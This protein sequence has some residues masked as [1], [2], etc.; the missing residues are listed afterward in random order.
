M[1]VLACPF[2]DLVDFSTKFTPLYSSPPSTTRPFARL[3][4]SYV[5][6]AITSSL[7]TRIRS[8]LFSEQKWPC[9]ACFTPSA[10]SRTAGGQGASHLLVFPVRST[11]SRAMRKKRNAT[12]PSNARP[13]FA[14]PLLVRH[15]YDLVQLYP[16]LLDTLSIGV[17]QHHMRNR[18]IFLPTRYKNPQLA[19]ED[20]QQTVAL[21]S[22]T[23]P[24]SPN[25]FTPTHH[26]PTLTKYVR[27][28]RHP[29]L[30]LPRPPSEQSV[31]LVG[32]YVQDQGQRHAPHLRLAVVLIPLLYRPTWSAASPSPLSCDRLV[33]RRS[34]WLSLSGPPTVGLVVP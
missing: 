28:V 2:R 7:S 15:A 20:E 5:V 34:V 14:N 19:M 17:A 30:D 21:S 6:R 16:G 29:L 3:N 12:P 10:L 24:H 32:H 8:Q 27:C 25:H 1:S 33:R 31:Q 9:V 11:R 18:T 13:T 22:H 4:S 26:S 23:P